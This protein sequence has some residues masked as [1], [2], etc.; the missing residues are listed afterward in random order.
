MNPAIAR[1]QMDNPN[2]IVRE[3][4]R[5]FDKGERT[6]IPGKLSIRLNA[7]AVRLFPRKLIAQIA[8]G[9]VHKLNHR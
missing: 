3:V 1:S 8:E 7:F 4:L 2:S 6:L 5:A 9:T